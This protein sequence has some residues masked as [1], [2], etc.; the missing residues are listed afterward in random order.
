MLAMDQ[1]KPPRDHHWTTD[2]CAAFLRCSRDHLEDLRGEG[3]GPPFYKLGRLVRYIPAKVEAWA[4]SRLV[5]STSEV[6]Q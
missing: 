2:E 6:R 5:T 4:A 1:Q 3:K